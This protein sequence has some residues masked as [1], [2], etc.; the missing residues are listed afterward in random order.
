MTCK[1]MEKAVGGFD[2][3]VAFRVHRTVL[4]QPP[5]KLFG[6]PLEG[7]D[8]LQNTKRFLLSNGLS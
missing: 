6:F 1:A 5:L 2:A 4:L 7:L 3:L 8:R